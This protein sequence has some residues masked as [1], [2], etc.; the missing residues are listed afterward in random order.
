MRSNQPAD[1][2]YRERILAHV[3]E[4]NYPNLGSIRDP[5]Q[6]IRPAARPSVTTSTM[7]SMRELPS[8]ADQPRTWTFTPRPSR[9]TEPDGPLMPAVP[10]S[11]DFS[12]PSIAQS[13]DSPVSDGGFQREFLAGILP[14]RNILRL[15][16]GTERNAHIARINDRI[17]ASRARAESSSEHEDQ[18]NVSSRLH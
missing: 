8:S 13:Q 5:P 17:R 9:S 10:E 14:E 4:D 1:V 2:R 16:T 15:R 6:Y 18:I 3:D 7:D 11:R 12:R